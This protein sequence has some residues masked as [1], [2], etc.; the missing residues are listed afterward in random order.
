MNQIQANIRVLSDDEIVR[1][2]YIHAHPVRDRSARTDE[3]VIGGAQ[4]AML[5]KIVQDALDHLDA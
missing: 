1:S 3:P 2:Q 5:D 4:C